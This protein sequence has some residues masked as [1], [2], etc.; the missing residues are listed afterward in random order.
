MNLFNKDTKKL[1]AVTGLFAVALV[2]STV[3][4]SAE[5]CDTTYGGGETCII[6]KS[7]KIRKWVK[8]EGDETWREEVTIDLNDDDENDKEIYFKIEVTNNVTSDD[9]DVDDMEFDDMKMKDILPDELKLDKDSED[10]PE[11][12]WDNFKAGDKKTF[13]LTVKLK[14]K[15]RERDGTFHKCAINKAE[16]YFDGDFEGADDA[17]V[18]WKRGDKEKIKELPKTGTPIETGIAGA[19]LI[20]LGAL[21]KKSKKSA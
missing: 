7:F 19:G 13:Y 5:E 14:D 4:V 18:C 6:N 20:V 15:E 12:N 1:I 3:S 17:A 9:V 16:L 10:E 8:L 11:E 21:I 2:L